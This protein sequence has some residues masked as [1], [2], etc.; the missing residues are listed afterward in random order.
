M[1]KN[2][3]IKKWAEK[4]SMNAGQIEKEF[5]SILAN[6]KEIHTNLSEEQQQQRALQRLALT[7]KKQLRSPAVGFEGIIIGA[8][9]C[10][11]IVAK[12]KRE[13]IA[14][15]ESDPQTAIGNG[16]V[17]EEGVPLDTR[18]TW[19]SGKPNPGFGKPLPENN[20][21]RT[22]YGVAKKT[23]S[24]DEPK[25]FQMTL[26]GLAAESENFPIFKGVRFMAI[27]KSQEGSDSLL[28][29]ASQFTKIVEDDDLKLEVSKD[30][31]DNW[32][33]ITKISELESYHA[34]NSEDYNRL[35]VVEG[36]VSAL[37]LEPTA[38]GSRI[39]NIEDAEASL[40]DLDS[41]GVTCWL[42]ERI[43]VDFAEGSKVLVIGR[44]GQGKKKDENGNM[45][46]ELGDVTVN[47]FGVFAIP[48]F[49]ISL[50]EEIQPITEA[51]I[52]TE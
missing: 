2:E 47:A 40:E 12:R 37:N 52:T 17:N 10:I 43:N 7:Y 35:V 44:T 4:L 49:K 15:Y 5:D 22:I 8:G 19:A 11:D 16:T 50:P 46:E 18:A 24:E 32:V 25:M 23:N 14:L 45:T 39:M 3:Y 26:N 38:F 1:D 34:V 28:L 9:D 20:F 33:G 30:L 27:N 13:A 36:D 6:E 48:E 21:L 29:N 42:P 51:D 31:I 41:K